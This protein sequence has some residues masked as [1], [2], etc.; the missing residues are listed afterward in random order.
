MILYSRSIIL[1]IHNSIFIINQR[2]G[3]LMK[4]KI[5][6]AL[7]ALCICTV[8]LAGCSEGKKDIASEEKYVVSDSI[9]SEE[10][11]RSIEHL[12]EIWAFAYK[13]HDL[14]NYN[15]SVADALEFG[16]NSDGKN[17]R[18]NN[19]FETVTDCQIINIDFSEASA[20]EENKFSV[21]VKYT[22]SFND[23]FKEDS[24]LKQGK[25]TVNAVFTIAENSG[26]DFYISDIN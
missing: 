12:I 23:K 13:T 5:L 22:I 7:L 6:A 18:T 1:I 14:L 19:Y 15:D 26:N 11:Q 10:K 24:Q 21:P 8:F 4:K 3:K 17:S 25:N 9:I 2:A 16:D 20:I